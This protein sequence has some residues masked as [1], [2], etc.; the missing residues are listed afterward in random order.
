MPHTQIVCAYQVTQA[1]NQTIA[2]LAAALAAA[3]LDITIPRFYGLI[4]I[5][6]VTTTAAPTATRT[7]TLQMAPVVPATATVALRQGNQP[8]NGVQ[9]ITLGNG[10][11][12]GDYAAPPILTFSG[13]TPEHNARAIA[14]CNVVDAIIV[15]GGSGYTNAATATFVGGD[16]SPNGRVAAGFV[17]LNA[18]SVAG[19]SFSDNGLL[20]H[21]FPQI[22][23]TDVPGGGSGAVIYGGLSVYDTLIFHHG[24]YQAPPTA[25]FTPVFQVT[26]PDL[27]HQAAAVAGFMTRVL[28]ETLR[29][30]VTALPPVVS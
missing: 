20:Y 7:I 2:N 16:V 25:V 9:S 27:S 5:K 13:G 17:S 10:D 4:P 1:G 24:I 21:T 30:S 23:I 14:L 22:V 15:N 18:G 28:A 29:S 3:P 8:G 26:N 6:D 19:I 12:N 11:A